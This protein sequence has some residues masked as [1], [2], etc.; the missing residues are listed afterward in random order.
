MA[1]RTA[2]IW[3]PLNN[4]ATPVSSLI[5]ARNVSAIEALAVGMER[6]PGSGD[7]A[8]CACIRVLMVSNGYN[9]SVDITPPAEAAR[10]AAVASI[11]SNQYLGQKKKK[12]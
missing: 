10:A 1:D 3:A 7:S 11:S 4:P 8:R 5:T 2:L 9:I 12:N 6:F